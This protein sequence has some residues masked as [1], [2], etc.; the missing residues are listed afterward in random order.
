MA[1][2]SPQTR[3]AFCERSIE[4]SK[5]GGRPKDYCDSTCRRRAQRQRDRERRV[6]V[7]PRSSLQVITYDLSVCVWQLHALGADQLPL[8]AVLE[9]TARLREDA[10]CLAAV[11]VYAARH[12]GWAWT[13][14][15]SAAGLSEA[16][17]RAR[18]GGVRASRLVSARVPLSSA[19]PAYQD[20]PPSVVCTE[21]DMQAAG[22]VAPVAV[23]ELGTALR[24]LYE[25]SGISHRR[26]SAVT[27]L[28]VPAIMSVLG[29]RMVPSWPETYMLSHALGGEPQD[30]RLLWQ[31]AWGVPSPNEM[32]DSAGDLGA[33]LR[34]DRLAAGFPDCTTICPPNLD[35]AEARAALEEEKVPDW[36]VLRDLLV[37]L[38]ANPSR[39]ERL[40]MAERN[41]QR[42]IREGE[43]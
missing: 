39:F 9:L 23:R 4:Q 10:D 17:A 18:W 34:G 27:G 29:G 42:T 25:R 11:A 2:P 6:S 31:Y 14:V 3:C 7:P 24:T 16:S 19:A 28:P 35:V 38:G 1:G 13:E 41:V 5:R 32:R 36:P 12:H 30:M 21:T 8:A 26:L 22:Q 40:W 37:G 33:A 43:R 15:A 20:L